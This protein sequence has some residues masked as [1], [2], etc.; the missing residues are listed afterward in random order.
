MKAFLRAVA[1]DLVTRLGGDLQH[2]AVV[3]NN[4]RPVAY[5]QNHLAQVIGKPFWSPAF[6]TIQDFFA[7]SSKLKVADAFTQFF[8]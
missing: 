3:F 5:L 8:T 1:E 2:T 6:Y 7:L 4:K